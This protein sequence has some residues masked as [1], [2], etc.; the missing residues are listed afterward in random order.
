[1]KRITVLGVELFA[2]ALALVATP[3]HALA[4]HGKKE[5]R[6]KGP[7]TAIDTTLGTVTINDK[8]QGEVTV[9][10]DADTQLRLDGHKGATLDMFG[11]GDSGKAFY[12]KTTLVASRVDATSAKI[13]GTVTAVDAVANTITIDSPKSGVVTIS[14]TSDTKIE[15]NGEEATLADFLV[16]DH[17]G[18][19]YNPETLVASR[20]HGGDESDED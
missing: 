6:A 19:K 1:M 7:I 4:K 13:E 18:A 14:A 9:T 15:Y 17:A 3:Q 20:I 5:A 10:V 12:D 16:G 8:R 2:L 11:V